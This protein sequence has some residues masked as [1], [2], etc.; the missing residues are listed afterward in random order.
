MDAARRP[1]EATTANGSAA[2]AQRI[3]HPPA[4]G[5]DQQAPAGRDGRVERPE[6]RRAG[7]LVPAAD[8][9]DE[10]VR[11]EEGH[12]GNA[13]QR[14][15]HRRRRSPRDQREQCRPVIDERDAESRDVEQGPDRQHPPAA[16]AQNGCDQNEVAPGGDPRSSPYLADVVGLPI[17]NRLATPPPEHRRNR[18]DAEQRPGRLKPRGRDAKPPTPS[19]TCCSVQIGITL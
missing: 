12:H 3:A 2:G 5:C 18:H 14:G 13:H 16:G 11:H 9:P 1:K 19:A 7:P 4:K 17:V 10:R 8:P 15:V 6:L